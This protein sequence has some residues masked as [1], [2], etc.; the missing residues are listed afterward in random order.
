MT[1]TGYAGDCDKRICA[2][3]LSFDSGAHWTQL[4]VVDACAERL[5]IWQFAWT[6][7]VPDCHRVLAR[8]V[9]EC[10]GVSPSTAEHVFEVV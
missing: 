2:I 6:P 3:W 8:A 1:F 4:P 9:N 5:V 10:G 7:T